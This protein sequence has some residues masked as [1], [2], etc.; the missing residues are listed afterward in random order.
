[1]SEKHVIIFLSSSQVFCLV[2]GRYVENIEEIKGENL[3]A[4]TTGF[5]EFLDIRIGSGL[6][7]FKVLTT[8]IHQQHADQHQ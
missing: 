5:A 1:M 3:S 2:E 4:S 8:V 6:T 7:M